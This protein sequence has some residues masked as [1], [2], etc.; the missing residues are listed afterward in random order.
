[1]QTRIHFIEELSRLNHDVLAMGT[2]VEESLRKALE[3]LKGQNVELAREVKA[4]D[5]LSTPFSS[6]SRTRRPSSSRR[7]SPWPG[8]CASS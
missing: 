8:T 2:R 6:R 3:A 5:E 1:M 7:S 4:S